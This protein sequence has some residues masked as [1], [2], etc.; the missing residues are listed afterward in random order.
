M[1]LLPLTA[2]LLQLAS[3]APAAIKIGTA[4]QVLFDDFIV[5]RLTAGRRATTTLQ[6][7][8][9]LVA[10]APW[11]AGLAISA[12]GGIVKELNGTVRLWYSLHNSTNNGGSSGVT[13]LA[14]SQNDGATFTKPVLGLN[15]VNT[16]FLAGN[17]ME[18]GVQSVWLDPHAASVD[19]IYKGQHEDATSGEIA[20]AASAD[21]LRWH[22]CDSILKL[23]YFVLRMMNF[24]TTC[25]TNDGCTC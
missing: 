24:T 18:N 13:A 23:M 14:V 17:P 25:I 22:E 5:E 19:E 3:S 15:G 7:T 11:E 2:A 8:V 16:N 4:K 9:V 12:A 20:M 6:P 21:G 10:D 1:R